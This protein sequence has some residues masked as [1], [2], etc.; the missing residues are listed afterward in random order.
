[1]YIID[2][3]QS[4][5]IETEWERWV[6]AHYNAN[7]KQKKKAQKMS[8]LTPSVIQKKELKH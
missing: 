8:L 6:P 5:F 7:T 2:M 4:Y 3:I 1:M